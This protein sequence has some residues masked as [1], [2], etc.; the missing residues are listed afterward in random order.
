MEDKTFMATFQAIIFFLIVMTVI[1]IGFTYAIGKVIS[2][3]EVDPAADN[4]AIL[5]H[6]SPVGQVAVSGGGEA[7]GPRSGK[8]L[9]ETVCQTCHGAGVLGAPKLGVK[10]DWE[11]RIARGVDTILSNAVNGIAAMPPR[12]GDAS[13]TDEELKAAVDYMLQSV[14]SK[15]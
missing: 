13:I 3:Q 2:R 15:L 7:S 1:L 6:I 12:G 14:G 9:A 4:A 8:Q 11:A 10:A 5:E